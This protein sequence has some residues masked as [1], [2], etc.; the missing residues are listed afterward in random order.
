[1]TSD[2]SVQAI[3]DTHDGRQANRIAWLDSAKG[4]AICLVVT[5]HAVTSGPLH[6]LIY[7]F[8][9]PLFLMMTGV[10]YQKTRPADLLKTQ[11]SIYLPLYIVYLVAFGIPFQSYVLAK[12][13]GLYHLDFDFFSSVAADLA[14]GGTRLKGALAAFWYLPCLMVAQQI[15]NFLNIAAGSNRLKLCLEVLVAVSLGVFLYR[16]FIDPFNPDD[17]WV[18]PIIIVFLCAGDFLSG[19]LKQNLFSKKDVLIFVA[20]T[21]LTLAYASFS[22]FNPDLTRVDIKFGAFGP[23]VLGIVFAIV[24]SCWFLMLIRYLSLSPTIAAISGSLGRA[25]LVIMFV[26]GPCLYVI[27]MV[28][29]R[30]QGAISPFLAVPGA[31]LISWRFYTVS[32]RNR[33]S[34]RLLV[35]KI[36]KTS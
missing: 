8:H 2:S 32:L 17:I 23:P 10:L 22:I 7:L 33:V 6:D 25:S 11:L 21:F 14:Y 15:Y 27:S 28:N 31:V 9:I 30:Y 1:M 24:I 29:G 13:A 4:Y 20:L 3:R 18:C 36:A 35:G 34:A 19:F 16:T 5:G 26:H 12:S